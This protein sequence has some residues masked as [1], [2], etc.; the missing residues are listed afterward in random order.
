MRNVGVGREGSGASRLEGVGATDWQG[1]RNVNTDRLIEDVLSANLEPVARAELH[2]RLVL[3]L[4]I[5]GAAAFGLMLTTVGPRPEIGTVAHLEWVALKLLFALSLIVTGAPSLIRSMR[6][7]P[8]DGTRFHTSLISF[9]CCRRGNHCAAAV[10]PACCMERNASWSAL[11][12]LR[13]LSPL[14]RVF[15]R[16]STGSLDLGAS[17]RC[18][19]P[20]G[21]LRRDRGDCRGSNRRRRLCVQLR[22]RFGA[23][24]R[25]LVRRCSS[26][27]C[28]HRGATRTSVP[29][30]VIFAHSNTEVLL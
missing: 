23:V 14:R 25:H 21:V 18:S 17:R 8:D 7:E 24:H 20:V 6:P 26:L 27:L 13:A 10:R 11:S 9:P 28:F 19:D 5:G 1:K 29:A 30:L 2:K 16:D 12:I 4:V 22:Q 3:A 15:R